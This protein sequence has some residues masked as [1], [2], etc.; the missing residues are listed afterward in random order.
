M[1][2]AR[3]SLP[4][5]PFLVFAV[6][7]ALRESAYAGRTFVVDGEADEFCAA[8][9]FDVSQRTSDAQISIFSNDSDLV[10]YGLSDRVRVVQINEMSHAQNDDKPVLQ[11]LEFCK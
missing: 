5:P 4:P 7:E 10:I 11:S 1:D 3:K 8:K 6:V 2:V 9:A